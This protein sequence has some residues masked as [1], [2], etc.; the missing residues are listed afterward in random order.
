M[1][2]IQY[3]CILCLVSS[4]TI[5]GVLANE[6]IIV[7]AGRTIEVKLEQPIDCNLDNAGESVT[8]ILHDPFYNDGE[9][10][11]P[12]GSI[13]SGKITILKKAGPGGQNAQLKIVFTTIE[14]P[15]SVKIPIDAVIETDDNSG[16]LEGQKLSKFSRFKKGLVTIGKPVAIAG[17][18]SAIVDTVLPHDI[19]KTLMIGSTVGLGVGI[20]KEIKEGKKKEPAIQTA[21]QIVKYT[22]AGTAYKV[23]KM[24]YSGIKNYEKSTMDAGGSGSGYNLQLTSGSDLEVVLLKPMKVSI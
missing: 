3:I 12:E 19:K 24:G 14:T 23:G 2:F 5:V 10:I 22:P 9:Y 4:V 13:L 8:A 18:T 15:D 6:T 16:I 20:V 11:L 7:P 21:E 17:A 1:R